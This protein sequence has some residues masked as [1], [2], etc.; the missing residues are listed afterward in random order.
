VVERGDY[1]GS[2]SV[3]G[4]RLYLNPIKDLLPWDEAPLERHV[5]KERLTMM[6]KGAST[7]LEFTTQSFKDHSWTVL[8]SKLGRF[9]G[10][11]A[12]EK[13]AFI[14]SKNKVDDLIYQNG[15]VVGIRSGE[16]EIGAKVV[17]AADGALSLLA[18]KAGLL[19]SK[20]PRNFAVAV[21]EVIELPRE[22]IEE[23]FNLRGKEGAAELFLGVTKCMGGGFL[24]TN[25]ES[26]SL[27]VVVSIKGLME[28]KLESFQIMEEFK[29]H[30]QV[31]RLIEGGEAVEYSAHLIPEGGMR[32]IPKLFSDGILVVGDAAGFALNMG[33]TVRGMDFA[34][35]SGA[36]AAWAI[37]K[38]FKEGDF[39]KDTLSYYE[40]LLKESFV[41]KDLHTFR[42]APDV[43]ENPRLFTYY[44]KVIC[45]LLEK[46]FWVP[47][48]PKQKLSSTILKAFSL[49]DL[50]DV[51]SLRRI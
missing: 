7:S 43:L 22:V 20:E 12:K 26:I 39:S 24:Y 2:K 14:I 5:V 34:I 3:T 17:V 23:R 41:L 51:I 16:A 40:K 11:K 31:S 37:K 28:M 19:K 47:Q 30:P 29:S 27:G 1:P 46:L 10:E 36:L 44:P 21:K 32:A 50:M 4:G 13:G 8:G 38:A 25:L 15:K 9:L 33:L 49:R 45:D 35:A 6:Q 18:E 48:G 42:N